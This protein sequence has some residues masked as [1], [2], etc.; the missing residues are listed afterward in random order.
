ML[1]EKDRTIRKLSKKIDKLEDTLKKT[2]T[3][4]LK[5]ITIQGGKNDQNMHFQMLKAEIEK[6][7]RLEDI[8]V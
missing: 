2:T 8:L 7:K 3:D 5:G 1:E 6:S 4:K